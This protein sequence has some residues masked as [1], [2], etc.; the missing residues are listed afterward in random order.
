MSKKARDIE[1]NW[2]RPFILPSLP[3]PVTLV[4]ATQALYIYSPSYKN[5]NSG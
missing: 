3:T 2:P 5:P 1:K 4:L